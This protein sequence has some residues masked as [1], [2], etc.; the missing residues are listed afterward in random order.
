MEAYY[1]AMDVIGDKIIA[2]ADPN[3]EF[4][5]HTKVRTYEE[6]NCHIQ[7][8]HNTYMYMYMYIYM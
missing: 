1:N 2:F 6:K 3:N 5:G 8:M 7:C 4:T